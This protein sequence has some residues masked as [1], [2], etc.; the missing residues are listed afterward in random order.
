MWTAPCPPKGP[1]ITPNSFHAPPP[2]KPS[3]SQQPPVTIFFIC[4][5]PGLIGYYHAFLSLL[6]ANLAGSHEDGPPFQVYGRSLG[7][8]ELDELGG[9]AARCYYDLEDQICFVM[10][11]LDRLM[12][13]SQ[14]G[15]AT[16]PNGRRKVVLVGHSVGSYIAMEVLR[17]HRET[18]GTGAGTD[19]DIAGGV[20]LFPTVVDIAESPSGRKLTRILSFIPHLALLASLLAALVTYLPDP[21]LRFLVGTAMRSPPD[22]VVDTTL[23]FLK[24]RRGVRQAIYMGA[25]EMQTITTDKWADDIWGIGTASGTGSDASAE[26]PAPRLVFYFGQNDHWVAAQTREDIMA[27]RGRK[28]SDGGGPRMLVCEDGVPHAFCLRHSG[29]MAGKVAGMIGDVVDIC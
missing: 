3:P 18:P 20:M 2:S 8:F 23:G 15:N 24:S 6:S 7:G 13:E 1:L 17:R 29:V 21:I 9:S 4:G 25:D 14:S 28:G 11:D 26:K 27:L 22:E 12:G 16:A 19:F 5:N 10:R